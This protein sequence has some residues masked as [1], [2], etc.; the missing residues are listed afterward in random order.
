MIPT[1]KVAKFIIYSNNPNEVYY[2][3]GKKELYVHKIKMLTEA[4]DKKNPYAVMV[5]TDKEKNIEKF[6]QQTDL[7]A[8]RLFKT[9]IF[10]GKYNKP[11]TKFVYTACRNL[12]GLLHGKTINVKCNDKD[13]QDMF[14]KVMVEINDEFNYGCKFDYDDYDVTFVIKPIKM[15]KKR[16]FFTTYF[17]GK[18]YPNVKFKRIPISYP[19]PF[20]P[21]DP[22]RTIR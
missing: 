9:C 3:L 18:K 22:L 13:L 1:K 7:R 19:Y 6:I 14:Y 12:L 8:M 16:V 17:Y 21:W 11:P 15:K 2:E 5:V 10:S 20:S 4:S